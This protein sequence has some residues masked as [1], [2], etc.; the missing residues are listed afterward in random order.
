[1]GDAGPCPRGMWR[2][3]SPV[4][5]TILY[6]LYH[7]AAVNL[8]VNVDFGH[9]RSNRTSVIIGDRPE[10]NEPS[11]P[12]YV[13][14]KRGLWSNFHVI[15][16]KRAETTIS[17]PLRYHQPTFNTT[18]SSSMKN[19]YS[20]PQQLPL[21]A[22]VDI[23]CHV[24]WRKPKEASFQAKEEDK[25]HPRKIPNQATCKQFTTLCLL[26]FSIRQLSFCPSTLPKISLK[27]A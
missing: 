21:T 17:V 14:D 18:V 3:G 11:R 24:I 10:K 7:H 23:H 1:M 27:H 6:H 25:L 26:S 15:Y 2:R 16:C 20:K 12:S 4:T 8:L 19:R 5:K 13:R 22:N 9:S